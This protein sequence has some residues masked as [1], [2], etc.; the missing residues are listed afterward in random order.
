M[1][2]AQLAELLCD[3]ISAQAMLDRLDGHYDPI[4][5]S[6][7]DEASERLELA[8]NWLRPIVRELH[9]LAAEDGDMVFPANGRLSLEADAHPAPSLA[10][11]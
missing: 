5:R 3:M 6:M 1:Q 9:D 11:A 2:Q 4:S 10:S 8:R 7:R